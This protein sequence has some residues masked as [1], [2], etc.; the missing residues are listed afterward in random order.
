MFRLC[1]KG[2]GSRKLQSKYSDFPIF[3]SFSI[4]LPRVTLKALCLE[5]MCAELHRAAICRG[6]VPLRPPHHTSGG[7]TTCPGIHRGEDTCTRVAG[8]RVQTSCGVT[9]RVFVSRHLTVRTQAAFMMK[10]L[11]V[12]GTRVNLAIWDT[13]GQERFHALGPI[14]Y[15]DAQGEAARC[16]P[17]VHMM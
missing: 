16:S 7:Q 4:S 8:T 14:Y 3:H 2:L 17:C 12:A 13:A 10:K 15:R 5:P 9:A 1:W 11:V 6:Q